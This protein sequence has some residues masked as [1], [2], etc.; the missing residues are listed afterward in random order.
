MKRSRAVILHDFYCVKCSNKGIGIMRTVGHL[1]SSMHLK[2][3]YCCTCRQEVNH[4]EIANQAELEQFK[5]NF[6]N[7]VYNG[8]E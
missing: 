2:K 4:V 6:E 5:I 1:H 8:K 3:L 7:G